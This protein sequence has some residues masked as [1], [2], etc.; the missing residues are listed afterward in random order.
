VA[1][2][3]KTL[4]QICVDLGHI[5]EGTSFVTGTATGGST[6]TVVDSTLANGIYADDVLNNREITVQ[7][8]WSA[9]ITDWTNSSGTVTVPTQGSAA[10]AA[11]VYEIRHRGAWNRAQTVLAIKTAIAYGAQA[12]FLADSVSESFAVRRDHPSYPLP[13]GLR[14]LSSVEVDVGCRGLAEWAPRT[15]DGYTALRDAAARTQVAQSF[16]VDDSNPSVVLGDVYLMLSKV[17]TVTGN[18]TVVISNDSNGAPGATAHATSA[19]VSASSLTA[20]PVLQRFTFTERPRLVA[21][22]T[23]WIVLQGSYAISSSNY[24]NWA[25]DTDAGYG[26]GEP[27]VYDGSGWSDG[28]GD[29]V[30][31]VRTLSSPRYEE[32]NPKV[33]YKVVRGSTPTLELTRAGLSL[34]DRYDGA[35][36]RLVGQTVP[37]LPSTDATTVE[38]PFNYVEAQAALQ[39]IAQNP[40]WWSKQ[41]GYQTMPAYWADVVR[42]VEPK[43][44]T[45]PH[46]GSILVA[47]V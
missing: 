1:I 2:N 8:K 41:P 43:L 38:L 6:T 21:G 19:T 7:S 36:I 5:L 31:R 28:T 29:L 20:E 12:S 32:L 42:Q 35:P 44:R 23:Y 14:F 16:E 33:H 13:S 46:P 27:A 24:V 15:W 30:F 9:T 25:N 37:S 17:G 4:G 40:A 22:T 3:Q 39:L 10:A 11:D 45:L 18:L 47:P 34:I 26:D